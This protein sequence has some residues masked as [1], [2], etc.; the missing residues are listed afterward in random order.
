M[1]DLGS[2][3]DTRAL[4]S[5]STA[6]TIETLEHIRDGIDALIMAERRFETMFAETGMPPLRRLPG[7]FPGLVR[8]I[9][10]QQLS[11]QSAAA[12]WGRM[13][14]LY[15]P[16]EPARVRDLTDAEFRAAGQSAAKVRAIRALSHAICEG[17]LDLDAL[18]TA[19]DDIVRSE[20]IAITGIGPWTAEVYLLACLG[21]RDAWP[22]GDVALQVA[23][24]AAFGLERRPSMREL[25]A[26]AHAWRPWRAVAARLIWAYYARIKP[27]RR[28][29]ANPTG[30]VE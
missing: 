23:V 12:I 29:P 11:L 14:S 9:T 19:P 28:R 22:A 25:D 27:M 16:L 17:Q 8:I 3:H 20:L 4:A 18:E 10:E 1:S 21:R 5:T 15:G 6:Q 24:Q 2:A 13:E 30:A 26:I 7:G